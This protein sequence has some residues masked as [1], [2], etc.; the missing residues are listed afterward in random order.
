MRG[1]FTLR[2]AEKD[3]LTQLL[4]A[5]HG[6]VEEAAAKVWTTSL[7][8]FLNRSLFFVAVVDRGVGIH[9]HG[10]FA[11]RSAANKAIETG[12]VFA[13]T[14]GSNGLVLELLSH[15]YDDINPEGEALW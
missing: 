4:M 12:D 2:K 1:K 3:A 5:E 14:P 7:E 6:T 13:A 8:Q 10:P 15:E 9:L 11:T